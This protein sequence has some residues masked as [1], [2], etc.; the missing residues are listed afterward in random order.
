MLVHSSRHD[1]PALS[2]KAAPSPREPLKP[3]RTPQA[4]DTPSS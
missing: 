3:K 1:P 2:P 4:K